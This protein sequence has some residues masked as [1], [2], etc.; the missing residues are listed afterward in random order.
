MKSQRSAAKNTGPPALARPLEELIHSHDV[1]ELCAAAA[2]S[3]LNEELASALLARGDLPAKALEQLSK[4]SNV[5]RDRKVLIAVLCHPRTP[6]HVS[7]PL[8]RHLHTFELL[9]V[10]L[11]P[12][13]AADLKIAV[14]EAL[15]TR[16][17]AIAAGERLTLA[18]RGST[19]VAAALLV[20][21]DERVIQAALANPFMT[22]EWVVKALGK[23]SSPAALVQAVTRHQ[24][25]SARR[26]V[27]VALLRNENTTLATALVC[28]RKLPAGVLREI[29]AHSRLPE[30]IRNVLLAQFASKE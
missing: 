12:A 25:W 17:Q 10:A 21:P 30:R 6:R 8:T 2:N 4:N 18:K 7:M 1:D 9:Q 16:M 28:A 23:P 3:S 20:D 11:T 22:E 13:L 26:D 15:I 29:L 24:K 14:E 5:A 27:Q 19:R